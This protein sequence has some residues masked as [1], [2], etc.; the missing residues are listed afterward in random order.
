LD[1]ETPAFAPPFL[2]LLH[3]GRGFCGHRG[4]E[5]ER[6]EQAL[7]GDREPAQR[8]ELVRLELAETARLNEAFRAQK[9]QRQ[10]GGNH[11]AP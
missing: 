9:M 8:Y 4:R 10:S 6:V 11:L 3:D 1:L 5:A 2:S 7:A